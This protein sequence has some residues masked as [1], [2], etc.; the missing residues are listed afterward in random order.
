MNL[1]DRTPKTAPLHSRWSTPSFGLSAMLVLASVACGNEDVTE[2]YFD[3]GIQPA[4]P[5]QPPL[6]M[7]VADS[8]VGVPPSAPPSKDDSPGPLDAGVAAPVPPSGQA[9]S[10]VGRIDSGMPPT[11]TTDAS[12]LDASLADGSVVRRDAGRPEPDVTGITGLAFPYIYFEREKVLLDGIDFD[13]TLRIAEL[14]LEHGGASSVLTVWVIRDQIMPVSVAAKISALYLKYIDGDGI[15]VTE[16]IYNHDFAVWH[17]A[18]AIGNIYRLNGDD[19]KQVTREAYEDALRRPMTIGGFARGALQRHLTEDRIY[20]G[21]AHEGGRSYA[22]S[23]I[24]IPGNPDY[25][26]RFEDYK[27]R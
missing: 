3:A 20:M 17:F 5:A 9:D 1:R 4:Q 11:P 19:I 2:A 26:Q 25:L 15:K 23:H 14:E 10:A 21:D 24:V 13:A 18:W 12:A 22:H 27:P 16:G 6:G 7:P 8:A